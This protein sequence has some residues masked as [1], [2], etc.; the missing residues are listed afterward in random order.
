MTQL[1]P[2]YISLVTGT[3]I[4]QR[5]T[6]TRRIPLQRH[7]SRQENAFSKQKLN[8]GKRAKRRF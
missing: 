6:D 5:L 8:Y 1:F 4:V 2:Q 3:Q 7:H